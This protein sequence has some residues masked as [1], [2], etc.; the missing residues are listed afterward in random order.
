MAVSCPAEIWWSSNKYLPEKRSFKGKYT[1]FKTVL[2]ISFEV[3]VP[4]GQVHVGGS[5]L[6][7]RQRHELPRGV[8]GHVPPQKI[9]KFRCLEM[10]FSPF[11]RQY[12]GLKNNQNKVCLLQPF[13]PSKSQSL[14]CKKKWN[15]K[16][17]NADSK[18]TFNN[19]SSSCPFEKMCSAMFASVR[20]PFWHM[21]KPGI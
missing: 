15:D 7:E 6:L 3:D 13:F 9:S 16:S 5:L 11:S 8:W 14:A 17:S 1:C 12:L 2:S 20:M 4:S 10:P 21:Q 19:L 18:N